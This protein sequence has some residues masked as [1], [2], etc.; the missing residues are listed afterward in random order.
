MPRLIIVLLRCLLIVVSLRFIFPL[1]A[2]S[3]LAG[4]ACGAAYICALVL[5]SIAG[6][7]HLMLGIA[8]NIPGCRTHRFSFDEDEHSASK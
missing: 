1:L 4:L 8:I 6:Y 2:V 5:A 3:L 7:F